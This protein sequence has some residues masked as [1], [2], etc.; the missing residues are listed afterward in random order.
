MCLLPYG[1]CYAPRPFLKWIPLSRF[2]CRTTL[3]T[4][5]APISLIPCE[6]LEVVRCGLK[7][8]TL[9]IPV[10]KDATSTRQL[11]SAHN[12]LTIGFMSE[13]LGWL[14]YVRN[15]HIPRKC[16]ASR[17]ILRTFIPSDKAYTRVQDLHGDT[18]RDG[19]S[20]WTETSHG[21]C[22]ILHVL[23]WPCM[24]MDCLR[25]RSRQKL[26]SQGR[27][28]WKWCLAGFENVW[29]YPL[30]LLHSMLTAAY[31]TVQPCV[32]MNKWCPFRDLL[33]LELNF[34]YDDSHKASAH[35]C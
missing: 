3:Y 14:R 1:T 21:S 2:E 8:L 30:S 12:T 34:A 31:R 29:T 13:T 4:T 23:V 18:M 35:M 5:N 33:P 28:E 9:S 16:V 10:I 27:G 6:E 24:L 25:H 32:A 11:V 22:L 20:S 7:V 15:S 17:L 26:S 19:R